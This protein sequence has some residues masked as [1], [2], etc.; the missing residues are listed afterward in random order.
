MNCTILAAD[1]DEQSNSMQPDSVINTQLRNLILSLYKEGF[2][3]FFTNCECGLSLW[4][5]VTVNQLKSGCAMR[6]IGVLPYEEQS[7]AWDEAQCERYFQVLQDADDIVL[8][9]T[10]WQEGCYEHASAYMT[11]RSDL[12]V[13]LGVRGGRLFAVRRR[14]MQHK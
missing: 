14:I 10:A 9:H 3:C 5:A 8:L 1:T 4:A 2:R 13:T 12:K 7:A 11:A 6:L